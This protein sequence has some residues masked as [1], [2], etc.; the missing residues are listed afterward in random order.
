MNVLLFACC[1]FSETTEL[2][3]LLMAESVRTFGGAYANAPIWWMIPDDDAH[4]QPTD[5]AQIDSLRITIT[6]YPLDEAI[7]KFPFAAKTIAAGLAEA[8]AVNQCETLVWLDCDVLLLQ[9]PDALQLPREK[10]LGC[11]PVDLV[12]VSAL[13]SDPLP[14]YWSEIYQACGVRDMPP[15][16]QMVSTIDQQVIFPHWNAGCIAVKPERSILQTWSKNFQVIYSM[17]SLQTFYQQDRR[18]AVF[19]HQ[20]IL[21]GTILALTTSEDRVELPNDVNFPLHLWERV[22]QIMRNPKLDEFVLVRY[23]TLATDRGWID[24]YPMSTGLHDWCKTQFPVV[25]P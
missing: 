7:Q 24:S 11:R 8:A 2:E 5:L 3:A 10:T 1:V 14:R 4:Y 12:N 16:E 21:A 23:D 20:A 9:S 6:R 13:K 19:A 22:N 18:Y 15:T 17:E 25:I